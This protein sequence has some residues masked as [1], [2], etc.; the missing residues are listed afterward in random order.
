MNRNV[1]V[2]LIVFLCYLG[3]LIS[4]SI[5]HYYTTLGLVII[6]ALAIWALEAEFDETVT[7]K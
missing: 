7:I 6:G 1:K 3:V 5:G 4:A 2:A